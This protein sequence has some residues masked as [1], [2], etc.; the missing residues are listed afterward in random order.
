MA[1]PGLTLIAQPW[2]RRR[3]GLP[4]SLSALAILTLASGPVT[5]W[6]GEH[7]WAARLAAV[8]ILSVASGYILNAILFLEREGDLGSGYPRRPFTL[9]VSSAT[10]AFWPMLLD[11]ATVV[12]LWIPWIVVCQEWV[13]EPWIAL[14]ILSLAAGVSW[15][16]VLAWF[17]FGAGWYRLAVGLIACGALA[18]PPLAV[19][20]VFQR[21][22][23]WEPLL[24]AYLLGAW[25]LAYLAVSRARR[26]DVWVPRAI[27]GRI[28]EAAS[29]AVERRRAFPSPASAQYWYE[30]RCQLVLL[31]GVTLWYLVFFG[32][33][34]AIAPFQGERLSYV[35]PVLSALAVVSPMLMATSLGV[36][37]GRS[38]PF[39]RTGEP[40]I[41]FL[42]VRP[43][44]TQALV[45]AK[46]RC[47]L[48][49]VLL[50]WLIV[51]VLVAAAV[52]LSGG[53]SDA[54]ELARAA[55]SRYDRGSAW[56]L[57]GLAV[58]L[59][60]ALTWKCLTEG[61]PFGL[62]GRRWV[63]EAH[64][65]TFVA[66]VAGIA[67]AAIWLVGHRVTIPAL[68]RSFP[69]L[70]MAAA[71]L[72]AIVVGLS[73]RKALER[74]LI[75]GRYVA[76]V[77]AIWPA[78]AMCLA[79]FAWLAAKPYEPPFS[80]IWFLGAGAILAPLARFALAPLALD[81]NRHR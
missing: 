58:I 11:V 81:W 62:C 7:W 78:F 64:T 3:V 65:W 20:F 44:S 30:A 24:I 75:D 38:E 73:F 77:L 2:R 61:L 48:A 17:P 29:R 59:A 46:F 43:M 14:P 28:F 36:R 1:S 50:T 37:F 12:A 70:V 56:L 9:P 5:R 71:P 76:A 19:Q 57:A 72:K 60:P 49:S 18:G 15:L 66:L 69:L 8:A 4:I 68:I 21:A 31:P 45:V 54:V 74:R 52:V 25:G 40:S 10:L 53:W 26:G 33:V 27:G 67:A 80:P 41:G 23:P 51:V 32:G 13:R 35:S 39:W 55:T 16:Q 42:S 34:L 22:V 6:A 63:S 47:A 79:G